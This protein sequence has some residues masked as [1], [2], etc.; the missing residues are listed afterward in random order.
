[1]R[2]QTTQPRNSR[3]VLQFFVIGVAIVAA[4]CR[5]DRGDEAIQHE[6]W[7][8]GALACDRVEDA[9]SES[10]EGRRR[11]DLPNAAEA[12]VLSGAA[13]PCGDQLLTWLTQELETRPLDLRPRLESRIVALGRFL[14]VRDERRSRALSTLGKLL[15]DPGQPILHQVEQVTYLGPGSQTASLGWYDIVTLET[16]EH[17]VAFTLAHEN[18]R[19]FYHLGGHPKDASDDAY[20]DLLIRY[21]TAGYG[22]HPKAAVQPVRLNH[23]GMLFG[24]HL[25]PPTPEKLGRGQSSFDLLWV[26]LVEA[27]RS[28]PDDTGWQSLPPELQSQLAAATSD[29]KPATE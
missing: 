17:W 3:G 12:V 16:L 7:V 8:N 13:G 23:R 22:P 10:D 15:L 29:R 11:L 1:V 5:Q 18:A 27:F 14:L 19:R 24:V 28:S 26:D 9:L 6:A 21:F 2:S 4:S 25:A 20:R